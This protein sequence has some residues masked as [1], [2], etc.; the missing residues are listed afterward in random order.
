LNGEQTKSAAQVLAD[1]ASALRTAPGVHFVGQGKV[2]GMTIWWDIRV[3]GS[4]AVATTHTSDGI[5]QDLLRV[6]G[7]EYVRGGAGRDPDIEA[8]VHGRW[9]EQSANT[10]ESLTTTDGLANSLTEFKVDGKVTRSKRDGQDVLVL[11]GNDSTGPGT[12][13]VALHGPPRPVHTTSNGTEPGTMDFREY[14]TKVSVSVPADYVTSAEYRDLVARFG[15]PPR[16]TSGPS[17][18]E[19]RHD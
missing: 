12:I 16:T 6:N 11:S 3:H 8:R 5:V 9:I 14:D 4:D 19:I 17:I 2:M 1:A 7:T 13:E 10:L 15:D 18:N